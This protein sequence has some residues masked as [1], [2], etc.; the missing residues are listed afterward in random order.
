MTNRQKGALVIGIL[1]FSFLPMWRMAAGGRGLNLW[2]YFNA[3]ILTRAGGE[4]YPHVT[5]EEAIEN[6][7]IAYC[8]VMGLDYEQSYS[9]HFGAGTTAIMARRT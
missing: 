9:G 4:Y 3:V 1:G 5:V 2:Q 7:R 6:A 8:E